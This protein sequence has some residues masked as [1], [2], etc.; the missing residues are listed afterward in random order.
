MLGGKSLFFRF[1]WAMTL[2]WGGNC[3]PFMFQTIVA[4]WRSLLP[5]TRKDDQV[6]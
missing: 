3:Q 2:E 4:A 6:E 1:E 5:G